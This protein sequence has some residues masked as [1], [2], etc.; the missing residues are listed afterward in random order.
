MTGAGWWDRVVLMPLKLGEMLLG[1]MIGKYS[2][3]GYG[4]EG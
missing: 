2:G 1:G 4:G 3:E